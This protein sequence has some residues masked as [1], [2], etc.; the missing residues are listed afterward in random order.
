MDFDMNPYSEN[1]QLYIQQIGR[2]CLEIHGDKGT[3]VMGMRLKWR[4]I[5]IA[6]QIAQGSL[7]NEYFFQAVIDAYMVK[8]YDPDNFSIDY[9]R[10]D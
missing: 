7:T 8:G 2:A 9:G 10:M 1:G 4:G 5:A 6:S 3:C